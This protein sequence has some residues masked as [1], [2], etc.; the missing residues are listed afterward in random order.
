MRLVRFRDPKR[1]SEKVDRRWNPENNT[2]IFFISLP[3]HLIQVHYYV[4]LQT[5]QIRFISQK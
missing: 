5:T 2:R 4:C 3:L 1:A